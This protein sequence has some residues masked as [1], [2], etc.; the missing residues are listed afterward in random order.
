MRVMSPTTASNPFFISHLATA[1]LSG[2]PRVVW[3]NQHRS[4][5]MTTSVDALRRALAKPLPGAGA[6]MRM[7]PKPRAGA[8]MAPPAEGW[9]PAAALLLLYPHDG[10]WHVLLTVRG[11]GLRHHTG[12]VSLPGGRLDAGES[13]EGAALREAYEEVGVE[14]ASV[15]VLG[16]LTPLEIAVS[17]HILNPVVGLTSERPAFRPHTVEVDCV[18]EVP[19][20]RLLAP[21]VLGLEERV[22]ARPP[23]AVMQ[24]PYFDIAGHHVWGATAMVLSELL[25]LLAED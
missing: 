17:G 24:V 18:L 3:Y 9:R 23:H 20:A 13:V 7:S 8:G 16:R 25:A 14:P 11:A 2:Y 10:E 5:S 15:E 12:Q 6:Q 1:G 19:L 22:Q 21:D 4:K